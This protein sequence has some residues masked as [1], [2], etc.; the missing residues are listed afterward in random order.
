M[1][2][3]RDTALQRGLPDPGRSA[4]RRAAGNAQRPA[5]DRRRQWCLRASQARL[6]GLHRPHA[7]TAPVPPLPYG[8]VQ[9]RIDF[10]FGVIPISLLEAFIEAGRTGLPNEVAEG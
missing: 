1:I 4:F 10:A 7:D 9:E 5:R 2:D 8:T 3:P 6:A